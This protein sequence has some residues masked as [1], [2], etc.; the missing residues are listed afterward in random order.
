MILQCASKMRE[1]K[2][3]FSASSSTGL[4]LRSGLTTL[5][6]S[7]MFSGTRVEQI[8]DFAERLLKNSLTNAE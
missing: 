7:C 8:D 4:V 6:E 2:K 5:H 1:S 3:R